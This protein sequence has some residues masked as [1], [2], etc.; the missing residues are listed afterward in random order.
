MIRPLDRKL[1]LFLVRIRL[2]KVVVVMRCP[3]VFP[4]KRT[5]WLWNWMRKRQAKE[6]RP[7]HH[8]P[9]CPANRW[10]EQALVFHHCNCGAVK[11][12]VLSRKTA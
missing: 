8:A 9:A 10:A 4:S 3:R 12:G 7:Y 2:W 11:Y 1:A 5:K 6:D